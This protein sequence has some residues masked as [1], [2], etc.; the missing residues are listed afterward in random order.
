MADK[1]DMGLDEIAKMNKNRGGGRG[2]RGGFRGGRGRGAPRGGAGGLGRRGGIMKRRSGGPAAA[3]TSPFKAAGKVPDGKWLHDMYGGQPGGLRRA[4]GGLSSGPT[5]L[6]ISNLDYGVNDK[7][8]KELFQD[9]GAIRKAAVHYDRSGRSL[10]TADVL[11][12]KRQDAVK[13]LNKYNGVQLDGRAMEIQLASN[14]GG[15][16]GAVSIQQRTSGGP[17]RGGFVPRGGRGG[18]ARGGY[19]GGRG[20]GRGGA[21]AKPAKTQAE[22]DA[23]LDSYTKMQ[24][25]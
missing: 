19:R 15:A 8:I 11:F 6:I 17:R 21:A 13:A 7:D 18:N 10:G 14:T 20:G 4:S 2:G 5:K 3:K 25:D 23:D 12:E 24:T 22:L 1:L 9:F 16:P